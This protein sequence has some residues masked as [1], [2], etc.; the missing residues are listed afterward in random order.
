MDKQS[1]EV[2][3]NYYYKGSSC[4]YVRLEQGDDYDI[5]IYTDYGEKFCEVST[6][7]ELLNALVSLRQG[8]YA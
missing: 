5:T 4:T 3:M 8:D 2:Q 6:G 7:V 1:I